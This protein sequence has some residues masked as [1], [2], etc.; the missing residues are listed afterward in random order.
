MKVERRWVKVDGLNVERRDDGQP[1]KIAGHAAV[2]NVFSQPLG[3]GF[4]EMIRPGAF[5]KTLQE[6]DI[7]ALFNHNPD[8]VLGRKKA[9][10]LTVRE[11][12][13]GLYFEV[14]PPDTTFARD[15]AVSIERGDIDQASFGFR[16]VKDEW[17]QDASGN[18]EREL[19][20]CELFDVSPVTFPAYTQTDVSMRAL[21]EEAGIDWRTIS[22][23]LQWRADGRAVSEEARAAMKEAIEVL[24]RAAEPGQGLHSE[25]AA[26]ALIT[27]RRHELD[28]LEVG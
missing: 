10:T 9:G 7:R 14:Q 26:K 13:T 12:V 23:A 17:K 4:R 2:F 20:E 22:A 25:E 21:M 15:L 28:L 27:M 18:S 5:A 16:T 24:Q 3:A 1:A 11:D 8:F 19:I 6:G